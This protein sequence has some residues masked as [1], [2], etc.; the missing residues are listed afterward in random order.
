VLCT[1]RGP[2]K[3]RIFLASLYSRIP[4]SGGLVDMNRFPDDWDGGSLTPEHYPGNSYSPAELKEYERV[5]GG[6]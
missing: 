2:Q 5:L 3:T 1:S 6:A 4:L